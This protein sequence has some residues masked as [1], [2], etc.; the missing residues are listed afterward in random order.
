MRDAHPL[1]R[2]P[3]TREAYASAAH[4]A[5]TPYT[6]DKRNAIEI[7]WHARASRGAS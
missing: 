2:V 6:G 4:V 7:G 3:L 5:P 1:A